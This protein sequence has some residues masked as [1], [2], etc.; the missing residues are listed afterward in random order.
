[1]VGQCVGAGARTSCALRCALPRAQSAPA[2]HCCHRTVCGSSR[3]KRNLALGNKPR[4]A[5]RIAA[6]EAA[7]RVT[8]APKGRCGGGEAAL[9]FYRYRSLK[10]T[11]YALCCAA[12]RATA[13]DRSDSSDAPFFTK[14]AGSADVS[15]LCKKDAGDGEG[16]IELLLMQHRES[17][18]GDRL[19]NPKNTS[20][21]ISCLPW[22]LA[23]CDMHCACARST[24]LL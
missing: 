8:A 9:S 18:A 16:Y 19:F 5:E 4:A 24:G 22:Y 21:H 2:T 12:T 6:F 20:Q 3:A 1:M 13:R 14:E 7:A 10:L 23:W 17:H 15:T 11:R